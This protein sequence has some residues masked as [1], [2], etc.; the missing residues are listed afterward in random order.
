MSGRSDQDPPGKRGSG[1]Y[2]AQNSRTRGS[3]RSSGDNP[4]DMGPAPLPL[5]V[6]RPS[7][8]IRGA[9]S[10]SL[11][12]ANAPWNDIMILEQHTLAAGVWYESR[13]RHWLVGMALRASRNVKWQI[14]DG[15]GHNVIALTGTC[16]LAKG[17][18]VSWR[19]T[20]AAEV[21]FAA[22][23]TNFVARVAGQAPGRGRSE[24]GKPL[25]IRDPGVESTL[26]ALRIRASRRLPG[27]A[28]VWRIARRRACRTSSQPYRRQ[29]C[30]RRHRR[31]ASR[32][33]PPRA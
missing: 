24:A 7:T 16:L 19:Q 23:N 12:S 28:C 14:A 26:L 20:Q 32:E 27:T 17:G 4:P 5:P 22:L 9:A 1:G 11:T 29:R 3:K 21:I 13:T 33:T 25:A 15:N 31:P 18:P 30:E 2:R 10:P 6:L 8:L